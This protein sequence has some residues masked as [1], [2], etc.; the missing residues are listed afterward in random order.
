[1]YAVADFKSYPCVMHSGMVKIFQRLTFLIKMNYL[2]VDRQWV[3]A[4][5]EHMQ[6]NL[7]EFGIG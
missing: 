7:N 5:L 6:R 3:L 1:M 2:I 4:L